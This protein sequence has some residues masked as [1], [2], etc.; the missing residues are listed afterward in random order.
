MTDYNEFAE[1]IGAV[2]LTAPEDAVADIKGVY[3][4]DLLSFAMGRLPED[5]AWV[6]VMGNLNVVAVASLADC[7]CVVIA[8]GVDLD[9]DALE[10][11]KQQDIVILKAEDPVFNVAKRI[12]ALIG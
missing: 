8:D 9:E 4:C 7:A 3:T 6:T 5:Y 10:K 2:L 12:D 11:A 1:K